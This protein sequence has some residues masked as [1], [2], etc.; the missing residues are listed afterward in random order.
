[1]NKHT[2]PF[3]V[4]RIHHWDDGDAIAV[5]SGHRTRWAAREIL[6]DIW[7]AGRRTLAEGPLHGYSHETRANPSIVDVA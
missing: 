3:Q 6:Y 7:T 2:A 1:M 5:M 4:V